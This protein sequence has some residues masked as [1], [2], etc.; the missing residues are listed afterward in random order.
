MKSILFL[1]LLFF[2]CSVF[3]VSAQD[4]VSKVSRDSVAVLTARIEILKSSIKLNELKLSEA[5][6]ENDIQ[7][8]K[9]KIIELKGSGKDFDKESKRLSD[10]LENGTE[11][12]VKKVEKMSK[13]AT[14]SAKSLSNAVNKLSRQIEKVEEIRSEIQKEERKLANKSPIIIY[15]ENGN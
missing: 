12:D 2:C 9:L 5:S 6:Q 14:S 13:K 15:T 11:T 3:H 10:A 1:F 7:K 4:Y 8:Q